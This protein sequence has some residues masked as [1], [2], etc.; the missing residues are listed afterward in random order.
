M[1]YDPQRIGTASD[2]GSHVR[3]RGER[4]ASAAALLARCQAGR[5]SWKVAP[6]RVGLILSGEKLVDHLGFREQLR[7][8]EPDAIGGEMEGAGLYAAARNH[9]VD[10]ILVKAITDWADGQK[11]TGEAGHQELAARNAAAFVLHVIG[12][13]SWEDTAPAEPPMQAPQKA[14]ASQTTPLEG[15]SPSQLRQLLNDGMSL[16]ELRTLCFDLGVDTEELPDEGK[17]ALVRELLGYLQ[18]RRRTDALYTW[19]RERRTDLLP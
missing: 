12:Q 6:V 17:S 16:T 13:G 7:Q 5:A 15:L 3:P 8:I 18:R 14:Q 11:T 10:W 9:N 19:L 1:L 4:V 2:G